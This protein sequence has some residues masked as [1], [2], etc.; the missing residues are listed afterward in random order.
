MWILISF[1]SC[2]SAGSEAESLLVDSSETRWQ[3]VEPEQL[4]HRHDPGSGWCGGHPG[5]HALQRHLLPHMG[6]SL[7]VSALKH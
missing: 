6:G 5:T 7:L 2:L 3:T 4:P 1:P